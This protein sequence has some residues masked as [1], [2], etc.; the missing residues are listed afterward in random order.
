MW[1][2]SSHPEKFSRIS[3]RNIRLTLEFAAAGL[4]PTC[5]ADRAGI[6]DAAELLQLQAELVVANAELALKG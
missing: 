5:A 4:C 3:A 6:D 1:V 2:L